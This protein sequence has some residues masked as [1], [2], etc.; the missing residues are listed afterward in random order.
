MEKGYDGSFI[1]VAINGFVKQA[2]VES[3]LHKL[4]LDAESM[5]ITIRENLF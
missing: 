4:N 3:T 1:K 5:Y 2:S